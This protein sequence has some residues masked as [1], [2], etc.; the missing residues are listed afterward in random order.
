MRAPAFPIPPRHRLTVFTRMLMASCAGLLLF[1]LISAV[2]INTAPVLNF[3]ARW[4]TRFHDAAGPTTRDV[5]QAITDLGS[6]ALYVLGFGLAAVFIKRGQWSLLV[7]WG[8]A[9]G[10]GKLINIVLK[11]LYA[12]PRPVFP[13]VTLPSDFGYPSGHT[14]QAILTYGMFAYVVW[15]GVRSPRVRVGTVLAAAAITVLVGIS[16]LMLSVH[17][18]SDVIGGLIAGGLWL[19]AAI[20]VTEMLR[21]REALYLSNVQTGSHVQD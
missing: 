4:A 17:F 20:S 13:D 19:V 16:R 6:P 8:V 10:V 11:L 18:V 14:M 15:I 7:G 1:V 12:R 5:F 3:D 9:T 21:A 2:V